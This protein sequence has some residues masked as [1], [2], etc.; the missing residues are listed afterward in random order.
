M[1]HS[2]IEIN[3]KV[4]TTNIKSQPRFFFWILNYGF[5]CGH[6]LGYLTWLWMRI[7]DWNFNVLLLISLPADRESIAFWKGKAMLYADFLHI[8]ILAILLRSGS[9]LASQIESVMFSVAICVY[10][11]TSDEFNGYLICKQWNINN[12][13]DTSAFTHNKCTLRMNHCFKS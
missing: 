6:Y 4:S 10:I 8:L 1:K 13:C 3:N 7:T 5:H 9:S 2:V 11:C 12:N